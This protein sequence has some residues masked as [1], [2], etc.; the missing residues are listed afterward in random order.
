MEEYDDY[1]MVPTSPIRRLEKRIGQLESTS[2]SSEVRR[3]IEQII[4]LIKSNQRVIDDLVKSNS[5]LRDEMS[6][7]PVKIDQL[8]DSMKEFMD[9]LKST[10]TEETV[11]DI[12]KDMMTP[13]VAKM[14][15]M[16]MQ[17]KKSAEISQAMLTGL[18]TIDKRFKRLF[19]QSAGYQQPYQQEG[20]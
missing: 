2:S 16:L 7:M 20:Q 5:E 3:L 6:K 10:A 14:D 15:E 13:V 18:E 1:E 19:L 4:E 8:L 11:T 12:S 9:I 17:N